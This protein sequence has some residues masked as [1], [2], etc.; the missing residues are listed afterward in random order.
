MRTLLTVALASTVVLSGCT[1]TAQQSS[2]PTSTPWPLTPTQSAG[3]G[4]ATVMSGEHELNLQIADTEPERNQ[5]LSNIDVVPGDGML[6]VF[7][8]AG[9]YAIWM[10]DTR[11]PL[12]ILWLSRGRI[13]HVEA[14]VQPEPGVADD[15]LTI[16]RSPEAADAIIELA[17]GRVRELG[18]VIGSQLELNSLE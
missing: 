17:A 6:F 9:E 2:E 1:M 4:A 14:D 7:D 15:A 3:R 18:L 13:V 10:K 8:T 16:Y 11:I 12:D 5:G